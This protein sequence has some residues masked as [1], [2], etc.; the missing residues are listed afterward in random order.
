MLTWI[1]AALLV[2]CVIVL[3]ELLAKYR[4]QSGEISEARKDTAAAK[5]RAN[6]CEAKYN[7]LMDKIEAKAAPNKRVRAK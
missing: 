4:H 2:A 7:D 1:L 6:M 5:M 3:L